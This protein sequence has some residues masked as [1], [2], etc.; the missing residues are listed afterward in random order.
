M[1]AA[2]RMESAMQRVEYAMRDLDDT[3]RRFAND[4]TTSRR[5]DL[6]RSA[7]AY[8][9]AMRGLRNEGRRRKGRT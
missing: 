3:A 2:Q 4:P 9:D 8:G 5:V 7:R 1:N 6:C